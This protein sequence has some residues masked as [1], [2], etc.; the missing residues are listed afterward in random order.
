MEI[1]VAERQ[2]CRKIPKRRQTYITYISLFFLFAGT[3]GDSL[4][5]HRGMS[6]TTKDRDNDKSSANWPCIIKA[7][8]G[9]TNVTT[10]I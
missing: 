4:A 10:P 9:T 2:I 3:A 1:I 8:G 6:F 7:G 5:Y